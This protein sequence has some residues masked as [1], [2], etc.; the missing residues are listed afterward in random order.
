MPEMV[1]DLQIERKPFFLKNGTSCTAGEWAAKQVTDKTTVGYENIEVGGENVSVFSQ[2]VGIDHGNGNF[3]H[4][5][6]TGNPENPA[7]EA[8]HGFLSRQKTQAECQTEHNRI[9]A[10]I[11][12]GGKL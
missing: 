11:K 8:Y 7:H 4:C 6:V 10:E 3:W 2:Y 12:K 1:T 5:G 9:V